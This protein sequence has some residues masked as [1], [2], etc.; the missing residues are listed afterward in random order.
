MQFATSNSYCSE[1]DQ[2][3][4]TGLPATSVFGPGSVSSTRPLASSATP[5][6]PP[7]VSSA[8]VEAEPA[9]VSNVSD[10][11]SSVSLPEDNM[12]SDEPVAAIREIVPVHDS[13]QNVQKNS[14]NGPPRVHKQRPRHRSKRPFKRFR[15]PPVVFVTRSRPRSSQGMQAFLLRPIRNLQSMLRNSV[16]VG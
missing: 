7:T 10:I 6:S 14:L 2:Y 5:T 3:H 13:V 11:T 8:T 9:F 12:P 1:H 16:L 4:V 15:T